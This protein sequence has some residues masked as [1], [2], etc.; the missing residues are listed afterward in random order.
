MPAS[1]YA[2]ATGAVPSGLNVSERPPWS[3]KLN[4]CF[5]TMSVESPTVRLKTSVASKIGVSIGSYPADSSSSRP[6][7]IT[8]ARRRAV[9][10]FAS[11]VPGGAWSLAT[12]GA[13][14]PLAA[15]Q[16][17]EERVR[18]PLLTQ[19]RLAHVTGVHGRLRGQRVHERADRLEQRRPVAAGQV[20]AADRALEQHV[21]GEDCLLGRDRERDVAWTVAGREDHIDLHAGELQLLAAA[22]RVLGVPAL[23]RAEP[24]PWHVG[25]DVGQD[26]LLDLGNPDLG[27][28]GPRDW[29]YRADVI[30]VRVGE[31][32]PVERDAE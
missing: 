22:K 18:R 12:S 27:A 15:G 28:R 5:W 10:A 24:R 20:D 17:L 30:E 1:M 2:R 8:S 7:A 3:S 21:A 16:L 26:H 9:P 6:A 19:R 13:V 23:E 4:I 29:R 11:S 31:Q 25:V 32:D 14:V